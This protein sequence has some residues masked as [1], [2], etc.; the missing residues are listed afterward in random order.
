MSDPVNCGMILLALHTNSPY[1]LTRL[2]LE[3]KVL[4][5]YGGDS[6]EM[7]RDLEYLKDSKY[8]M[9]IE[10]TLDGKT[11]CAFKIAPAGTNL[12]MGRIQDVGVK[13]MRA[14]RG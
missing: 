7:A 3:T 1:R 10:E 8:I 6:R 9:E 13:I 11:Y 2:S 14:D 12:V 4:P 5:F